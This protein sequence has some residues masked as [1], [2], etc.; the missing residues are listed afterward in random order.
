MR[1]PRSA[2][3]VALRTQIGNAD[4]AWTWSKRVNGLPEATVEDLA[5]FTLKDGSLR[6]L[7]A[8]IAARGVWELRLDQPDVADTTYLRCHQ[9]D[10][11]YRPSTALQNNG[12]TPRSWHGSPD[13][14]PRVAPA[15]IPR[16]GDL[17]WG[18]IANAAAP[19]INLS[20]RQPLARF[21]AALRSARNDLRVVPN[22]L[23]DAYFSEVL[24]D[25]GAPVAVVPPTGGTPQLL[26]P[27][28]D[29]AFWDATMN[30][31]HPGGPP[32]SLAEPWGTGLPTEADLIDFHGEVTE[33]QVTAAS[34]TFPRSRAIVDVVVHHR[35]LLER[36]G[37]D[38]RVVLLRWSGPA[39]ALPATPSSW[40]LGDGSGNVPW[41]QAVNQVLNSDAGTTALPL[42][43]GWSFVP[44]T[45][46][47]RLWRS[48]GTTLDALNPGTVQFDVD[49]VTGVASNRVV[50]LVAVLR[51]GVGA[52][53]DIDLPTGISLQQLVL[54]SPN[55]AVRSLHLTP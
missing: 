18:S 21:Q 35:G 24:R 26:V 48:L 8:A 1:A 15:V 27:T 17:P 45:G 5:I 22:G 32:H 13:V 38:V 37:A 49:L 3:G 30:A 16:P 53:A 4:P 55:V 39:T 54:A 46:Q 41:T 36:P 28:I 50:V 42:G 34:M 52:S 33:G 6:L 51:A 40:T 7:R 14:R 2:C 47:T 31:P 44:T 20:R 11:R 19:V 25:L 9:A 23:W 43:A 12:R 10:L 29:N